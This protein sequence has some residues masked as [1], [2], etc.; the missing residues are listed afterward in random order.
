MQQEGNKPV[1]FPGK[2]DAHPKKLGKGWKNWWEV[3]MDIRR[4]RTRS[5]KEVKK[6]IEKEIKDDKRRKNRTV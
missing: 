4:S 5:K 6:E 1:R 3:E 2:T